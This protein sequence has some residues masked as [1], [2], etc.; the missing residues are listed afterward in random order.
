MSKKARLKLRVRIERKIQDGE[1]LSGDEED[2][3]FKYGIV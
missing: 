3:A 2:F 1:E